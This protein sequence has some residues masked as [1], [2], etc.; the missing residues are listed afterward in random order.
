MKKVL[1]VL[2]AVTLLFSVMAIGFVAAAETGDTT[3]TAQADTGADAGTA[4]EKKNDYPD[5]LNNLINRLMEVLT[6]LLVKF[7]LKAAI[8]NGGLV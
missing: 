6:K 5:W 2:L 8:K 4:T 1:A 3:V 7:G